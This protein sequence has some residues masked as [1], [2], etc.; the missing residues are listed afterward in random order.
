MSIQYIFVL[1]G[2]IIQ[3]GKIDVK[4]PVI[5]INIPAFL[6]GVW[7]PVKGGPEPL[8][9]LRPR[10][11]GARTRQRMPRRVSVRTSVRVLRGVLREHLLR[12]LLSPPYWD[13]SHKKTEGVRTFGLRTL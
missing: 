3:E 11:T 13:I 5:K 10:L 2:E 4:T 6:P 9:I 1:G 7:N 12:M 8:R